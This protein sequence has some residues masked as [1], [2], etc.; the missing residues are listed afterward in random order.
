M[1][2]ALIIVDVQN[3][4][5]DGGC[6]P[7]VG[8]TSAASN[9]QKLLLHFRTKNIPVFHIQHLSIQKGAT[10]FI[11]ETTGCEIHASVLPGEDETV[12][13]KNFPSAFR[14]TGLNGLLQKK[15]F[16]ALGICGA[17]SQYVYRY[18]NQGSF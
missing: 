13:V 14:G 11:P 2:K 8:M 12:I 6:M 9:V 7:L 4:Y 15:G 18:H 16:E 1:S 5:F 10:F 17:M 3:D